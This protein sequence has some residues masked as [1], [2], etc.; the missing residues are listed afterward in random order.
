MTHFNQWKFGA[1]LHIRINALIAVVVAISFGLTQV[2]GASAQITSR[3]A[4]RMA[5][6]KRLQME[7]MSGSPSPVVSSTDSSVDRK[8]T[9][10]GKILHEP[11]QVV[12]QPTE[13]EI[14]RSA[15]T[16]FPEE[17]QESTCAIQKIERS[18]LP[19]LGS[20]LRLT[21]DEEAELV[22][23]LESAER[24][25]SSIRL[26]SHQVNVRADESRPISTPRSVT[27]SGYDVG[28]QE[29]AS[30]IQ[31]VNRIT[32]PMPVV[33]AVD[34]PPTRPLDGRHPNG[35]SEKSRRSVRQ[36]SRSPM[37][38]RPIQEVSIH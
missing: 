6:I 10:R 13:A 23:E 32:P 11:A 20:G 36:G 30:V 8:S 9:A 3:D 35:Y 19:T 26:T 22:R 7:L 12:L 21:T 17:D 18:G 5:R 24:L 4:D 25:P 27:E 2:E 29:M 38:F 16:A 31:R 34:P 1:Q 15:L 33:E 14:R 28:F 37:P